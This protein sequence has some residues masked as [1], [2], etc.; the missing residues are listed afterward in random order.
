MTKPLAIQQK[1]PY[2][3]LGLSVRHGRVYAPDHVHKNVALGRDHPV[4]GLAGHDDDG[5]DEHEEGGDAEGQAVAGRVAEA[6][7]VLPDDGRDEGREEGAGVDGKVKH[8]EKGLQLPL[9]LGQPEL[10]AAEGGHAGLDA[11]GA[12]GDEGEAEEA[13]LDGGHAEGRHGGEGLEQVAEDVDEGDVD[14]RLELAPEDV[15]DHGPEDGGEVAEGGEGVV[16]DGGLVFGEVEL[17]LQVQGQD[18]LHAVV[19]EPLAKL[20]ADDEEDRLGVGVDLP[21]G[22]PPLL[23]V[24]LFLHDGSLLCLCL[25]VYFGVSE[26]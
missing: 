5:G 19:G 3:L 12:Y 18:G 9:L 6:L 14:D 10:V 21:C 7:D 17:L 16:D 1:L 4:H 25:E 13:E 24:A 22:V 2:L 11:A 20:V 8:G 23:L 15:G 26:N